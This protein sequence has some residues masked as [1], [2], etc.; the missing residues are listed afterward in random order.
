MTD[1]QGTTIAVS[2]AAP[3]SANL[4]TVQYGGRVYRK[5][6][7]GAVSFKNF[8]DGWTDISPAQQRNENP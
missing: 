4:V 6:A 8:P 7:D 2:C 3:P 1:K 5:Y